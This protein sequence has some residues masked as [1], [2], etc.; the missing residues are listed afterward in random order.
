[1]FKFSVAEAEFEELR[2]ERGKFK[3]IACNRS[4]R[5]TQRPGQGKPSQQSEEVQDFM[6]KPWLAAFSR[7]TWMDVCFWKD[8][9][10]F[11]VEDGRAPG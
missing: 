11:S 8:L 2:I 4:W 9:C 7:N 6:S 3:R 10:G 5:G 1:M